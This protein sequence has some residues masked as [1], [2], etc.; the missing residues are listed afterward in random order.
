MQKMPMQ[1]QAHLLISELSNRKPGTFDQWTITK[2]VPLDIL[3]KKNIE[4]KHED[5][6]DA[7]V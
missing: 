7:T 6:S 5:N 4:E 2:P 3:L 1:T